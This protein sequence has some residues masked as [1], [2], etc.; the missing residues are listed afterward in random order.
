MTT[1]RSGK[2]RF[3]GSSLAWVRS[4]RL[5][6]AFMT[7]CALVAAVEGRH[8]SLAHAG[9]VLQRVTPFSGGDR[10]VDGTDA[11][12]VRDG[13]P[14]HGKPPFAAGPLA[15]WAKWGHF[16]YSNAGPWVGN[17]HGEC[18]WRRSARLVPVSAERDRVPELLFLTPARPQVLW[19]CPSGR[20]FQTVAGTV[21]HY[22]ATPALPPGVA[23]DSKSGV[24]AGTPSAAS[25][26][27]P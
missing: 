24:I 7:L 4:M 12:R 14:L 25:S 11:R 3:T 27:A 1:T 15:R 21:E 17:L 2:R 16:R 19:E 6:S 13:R 22:A 9:A 18:P 20:G 26:L 8:A 10:G 23:L 5:S